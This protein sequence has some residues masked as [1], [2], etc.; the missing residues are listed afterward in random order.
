MA[1]EQ[2]LAPN[3][4]QGAEEEPHYKELYEKAK[5]NS[6]KWELG[7]CASGCLCSR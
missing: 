3:G 1:E 4:P 6:R 7:R 5:A 2:G